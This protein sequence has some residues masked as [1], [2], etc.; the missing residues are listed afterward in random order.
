MMERVLGVC[1]F[2]PEVMQDLEMRRTTAWLASILV[3]CGAA[4]VGCHAD[5]AS[6]PPPVSQGETPEA[7]RPPVPDGSRPPAGAPAF[8]QCRATIAKR[9]R[10][11]PAWE[12]PWIEGP[13]DRSPYDG[14]SQAWMD[15]SPPRAAPLSPDECE[16]ARG[17]WAGIGLYVTSQAAAV[18]DDG[19]MLLRCSGDCVV[20]RVK[21]GAVLAR[22][23]SSGLD[24]QRVEEK[25]EVKAAMAKLGFTTNASPWPVADALLDWSL[26]TRGSAVTYWLRDRLTP[27]RL[28]LGRFQSRQEYMFPARATWS[29]NGLALVLTAWARPQGQGIELKDAVVDLPAATAVLY[30]RAHEIAP[31]EF[32]TTRAQRACDALANR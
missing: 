10:P 22:V 29:R 28:P 18:S 6:A 11:S 25:P 13:A 5:R 15:G 4:G 17:G 12:R 7:S 24:G 16:D 20:V 27:A 2:R 8:D 31:S 32:T 21:D 30:L 26:A 14:C 1:R 19:S 3:A 9:F 23:A